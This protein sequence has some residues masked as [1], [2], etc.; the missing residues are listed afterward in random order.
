MWLDWLV[1]W[2][3]GFQ[4]I[5][6]LMEKDKRLM[7]ASWWER[8][9]RGK[10]GL[11]LMGRAMLSKSLIQFS[12]DGWGCDPSLLF[13]WGQGGFLTSWAVREAP[14]VCF[15]GFGEFSAWLLWILVQSCPVVSSSSGTVRTQRL[16]FSDIAPWAYSPWGSV[17]F[18]SVCFVS[19]SDWILS[20][21]LS[22]D[23]VFF[24]FLI[25]PLYSAVERAIHWVLN[26]GCF[27]VLKLSF[28]SSSYLLFLC[29]DFLSLL[30]LSNLLNLF[31]AYS[32]FV[33]EG[34]LQCLL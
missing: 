16:R 1:F 32:R 13:A 27:S 4:S 22:S 14:S 10:L 11:V 21:V 23:A 28:G 29:E 20:T 2:D 34:F 24:F 31:Q 26:F 19:C 30:W 3:C 33:I 18:V 12:V 8:K 6:P 5:C 7:E 15:A 9:L 25:S 17:W